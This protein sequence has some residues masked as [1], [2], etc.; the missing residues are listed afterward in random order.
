MTVA[1]TDEEAWARFENEE[2]LHCA[3][4]L[5]P[6]RRGLESAGIWCATCITSAQHRGR[7]IERRALHNRPGYRDADLVGYRR[8][9]LA[10]LAA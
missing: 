3:R 9:V 6:E 1:L 8:R 5:N 4:P 7:Q 10:F 2:C